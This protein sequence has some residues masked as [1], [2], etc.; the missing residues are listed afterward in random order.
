MDQKSNEEISST[1]DD[2]TGISGCLNRILTYPSFLSLSSANSKENQED[3]TPPQ[4]GVSDCL[5]GTNQLYLS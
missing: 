3:E 4:V 2:L 5:K 1:V